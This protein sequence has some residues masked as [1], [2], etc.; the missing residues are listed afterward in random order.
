G[1][2]VPNDDVRLARLV[3]S[4]LGMPHDVSADIPQALEHLTDSTFHPPEPLDEPEYAAW[5]RLMARVAKHERAMIFGEDGDA[6]FAP[7]SLLRTL[8]R[9]PAGAVLGRFM[10]QWLSSGRRPHLGVNWRARLAAVRAPRWKPV[11]WLRDAFTEV[12]AAVREPDHGTHPYRPEVQRFLLGTIWQSVHEV[13]SPAY[14][15]ADVEM[16]WPL[17]DLRVL[18]FALAIPPIPWCQH[19]ELTR[20]AFRD[21]LPVEV[22]GRPKT[23]LGGYGTAKVKQW[24]HATAARTPPFMDRTLEYIDTSRVTAALA[25]GAPDDIF[26]AWRVLALDSWLREL[27]RTSA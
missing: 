19:K 12:A 7:P 6:L 27:E 26:A 14:S 1:A 9:W 21:E 24:R 2:I 3:A 15:G 20:R 25:D 5:R 8:R 16:R 10:R 22:L 18:E 17:L 13:F 11:P 23:T 4:R